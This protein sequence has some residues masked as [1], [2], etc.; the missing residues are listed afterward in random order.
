MK[1]VFSVLML[2]VLL[3]SMLSGCGSGG[4]KGVKVIDIKLTDESYAF[5][6]DKNKPELLAQANDYIAQ[7]F[8]DGTFD[9]ICSH[10][11]GSGTPEGI[12]SAALDSSKDQLIVATNATFPPFEYTEG[13][14][15][16]GIDME[17]AAGLAKALG[18]E[19]VIQDMAF[20]SVCLSVGQSK[21]DIAMAGLTVNE[22]RKEHV[23]F[24][25]SYYDASQIV[26]VR[27]D[28]TR[29]DGCTTPADVEAVLEKWPASAKIG[30]QNGTTAYYYVNGDEEWGFDGYTATCMGYDAGALAVQDLMNGNLDCVILDEAPAKSIAEAFNK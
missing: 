17:I 10:F 15:F 30:V 12:T 24:T 9:E 4:S 26:L 6:V 11:F 27:A 16:Y 22:K 23:A 19:L 14:K 5:G 25:D 7:I 29:F 2:L 1:K 21:C 3:I 20:E 28:D 8:S 13:S 18:K